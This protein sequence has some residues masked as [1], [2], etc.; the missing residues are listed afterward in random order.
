MWRIRTNQ[1]MRKLDLDIVADIKKKRLEG[2][3][4]VVRMYQGRTV[5]KI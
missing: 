3:G 4:R 2:I 1:E 5:K